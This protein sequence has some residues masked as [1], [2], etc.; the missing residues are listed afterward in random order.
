MCKGQSY[1]PKNQKVMRNLLEVKWN[2]IGEINDSCK[3]EREDCLSTQ[4][5]FC[6]MSISKDSLTTYSSS[7]RI[8]EAYIITGS[9]LGRKFYITT[10]DPWLGKLQLN[11]TVRLLSKD[12]L[13]LK[14][15]AYDGNKTRKE[16]A[17]KPVLFLFHRTE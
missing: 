1:Y 9:K 11:F 4:L 6:L 15:L 12:F 2:L 5:M 14:M 13:I 3:I 16:N 7:G 17:I 8:N 10:M